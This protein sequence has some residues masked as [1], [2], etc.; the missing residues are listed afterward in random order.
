[1]T[2]RLRRGDTLLRRKAKRYQI[3]SLVPRAM[4]RNNTDHL[5]QLH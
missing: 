1:M 2:K 3:L 4:R 5:H